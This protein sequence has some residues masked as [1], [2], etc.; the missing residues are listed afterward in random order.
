MGCAKREH[1][2][3][4][5]FITS[6]FSVV[7]ISN[8]ICFNLTWDDFSQLSVF[9][10]HVQLVR[11]HYNNIDKFLYIFKRKE[12]SEDI[13]NINHLSVNQ[14]P[15]NDFD[16]CTIP[17]RESLKTGQRGKTFTESLKT[18]G[19]HYSASKKALGKGKY[20]HK[21]EGRYQS[22]K[23]LNSTTI[24]KATTNK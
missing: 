6:V 4:L 24:L 11:E 18:W 21:R 3:F 22:F 23:C 14:I 9:T 10:L 1:M 8:E 15:E 5:I 7:P 16:A 2:K 12:E 13:G 17:T 19:K 20:F